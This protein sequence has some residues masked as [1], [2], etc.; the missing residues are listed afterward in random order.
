[1]YEDPKIISAATAVD[2]RGS[3][4]FCNDFGLAGVNRFYAVSNH[5]VG[6][7][8]AWHGHRNH[9]T[10]L[11]PM[12]GVWHAAAMQIAEPG[13][14]NEPYQGPVTQWT[15]TQETILHIPGGWFHGH[16]NLTDGVLGVFST[17]SFE[18]VKEDDQRIDW[19]HKRPLDG[20]FRDVWDERQR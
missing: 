19:N 8:R 17:A 7:V 2:D 6:F 10:Y 5:R 16:K 9:A 14:D 12:S 1:M 13:D 20:D 11:W 15:L 18:Q 3:L 4:T